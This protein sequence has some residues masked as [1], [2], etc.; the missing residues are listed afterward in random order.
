LRKLAILILFIFC[1]TLLPFTEE[2]DILKIEA[3]VNPK[4]LSKGQD[5]KVILK[6]ILVEGLSITPQPS[7]T[8]EFSPNEVI[9]F[10]KKIFSDADL[11]MEILEDM[12]EEHLSLKDPIEIPFAVSPD[13]AGGKQRLDG[14]INYFVCSKEEGWCLK[15][16]SKF[17]VSFSIQA[18]P[19]EKKSPSS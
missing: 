2:D 14:K 6:L 19:V 15:S 17:S 11:G 18:T 8:V 10:A 3:S 5:G 9:V 16:S 13:A 1:F 12:G 7:F 4:S